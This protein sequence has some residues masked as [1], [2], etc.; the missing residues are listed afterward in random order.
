MQQSIEYCRW[1]ASW[2]EEQ[3][4]RRALVT[5]SMPSH[6]AE[7]IAAYAFEQAD[8]ERERQRQWEE[9]WSDIRQRATLILEKFLGEKESE[10]IPSLNITIEDEGYDSDIDVDEEEDAILLD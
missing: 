2:W 8:D 5:P 4:D 7:G 1:K 6:M 3:A 9:K 10:S